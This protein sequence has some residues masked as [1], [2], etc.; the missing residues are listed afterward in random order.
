VEA[1]GDGWASSVWQGATGRLRCVT[2]VSG[3]TSLSITSVGTPHRASSLGP[4][5]RVT[6][7]RV[8]VGEG[9]RYRL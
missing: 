2:E 7:N 3:L 5:G 9:V 6:S 1:A 4:Q 8:V